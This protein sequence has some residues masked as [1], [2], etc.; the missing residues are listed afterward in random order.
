MCSANDGPEWPPI[1]LPTTLRTLSSIL[2]RTA[3]AYK[4]A[5][6]YVGLLTAVSDAEAGK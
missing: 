3:S 4:P 5:A 6:I 1:S 2:F